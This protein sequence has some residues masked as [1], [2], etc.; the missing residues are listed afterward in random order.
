MKFNKNLENMKK[1]KIEN[2]ALAAIFVGIV[3]AAILSNLTELK[4]LFV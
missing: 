4:L 2:I 1:L 3:L